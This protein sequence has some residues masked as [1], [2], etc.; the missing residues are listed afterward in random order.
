MS[1]CVTVNDPA[2]HIPERKILQ[3][4]ACDRQFEDLTLTDPVRRSD[5]M[6][7]CMWREYV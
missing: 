5:T 6:R 1:E 2:G 3:M 4:T 7:V